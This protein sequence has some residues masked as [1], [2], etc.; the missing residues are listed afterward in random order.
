M[1]KKD[2]IIEPINLTPEEFDELN[3]PIKNEIY[4]EKIK[5]KPK[6]QMIKC[7]ICGKFYSRTNKWAHNHTEYHRAYMNINKKLRDFI[8]HN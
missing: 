8:L 2:D 6:K 1:K 7:D 4:K 3:N 5:D